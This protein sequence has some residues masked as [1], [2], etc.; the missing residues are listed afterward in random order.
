[1]RAQRASRDEELLA[2]GRSLGRMAQRHAGSQP[3]WPGGAGLSPGLGAGPTQGQIAQAAYERWLQHG[4]GALDNW[5]AAER[6]LRG[7][8]G[9]H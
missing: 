3:S 1:M 9:P 7:G 6:E 4:G 2:L 5:L 8:H